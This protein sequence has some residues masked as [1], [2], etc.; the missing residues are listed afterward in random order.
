M[1]VGAVG[2]P[3]DEDPTGERPAQ[4]LLVRR[5][6]GTLMIS[7]REWRICARGWVMDID[8]GSPRRLTAGTAIGAPNPIACGG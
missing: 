5:G 2:T 4:Q 7:T 6:D 1:N 8:V 3:D